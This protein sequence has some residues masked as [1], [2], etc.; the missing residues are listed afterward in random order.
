MTSER[1]S[2]RAGMACVAVLFAFAISIAQEKD[3]PQSQPDQNSKSAAQDQPGAQTQPKDSPL[4]AQQPAERD[5]KEAQP[6]SPSEPKSPARPSVDQPQPGQ[7]SQPKS[8]ARPGEDDDEP[9]PGKQGA[10]RDPRTP[11]DQ[12]RPGERPQ[13][14]REDDGGQRPGDRQRSGDDQQRDSADVGAS[15]NVENDRL[16]VSRVTSNSVA[17]R[18]GLRQ[19][20]VIVSINGQLVTSQGHWHRY[21][22]GADYGQRITVNVIRDGRRQT[23]YLQPMYRETRRYSPDYYDDRFEGESGWLGVVLDTRYPNHAVVAA[24]QADSAADHAGLRAGDMIVSIDGTRVQSVGHLSQLIGS[25]EP[26]TN[27]QLE[28]AR[29]QIQDVQATLGERPEFRSRF[30]YEDSPVIREDRFNGQS[31][32]R[33]DIRTEDR[34]DGRTDDRLDGRADDRLDGRRTGDQLDDRL[35]GDRDDRLP[36]SQ[37]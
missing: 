2:L 1:F 5:K 29:R 37:P 16:T 34:L 36:R 35:P 28:I 3:R 26:G 31:G 19:G 21:L 27:V 14:D 4:K 22:S 7:P 9:Q 23:L 10:P 17:A 33:I 6:S 32:E 8:P 12:P 13:D 18:A 15:F 11:Q 30:R 25:M 20:D 24:V